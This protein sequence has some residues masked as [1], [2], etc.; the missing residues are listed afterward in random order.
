MVALAVAWIVPQ[1][2]LLGL[3]VIPRFLA[4]SALAFAPVFLA[5]LIF[6]VTLTERQRDPRMRS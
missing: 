3:P 5:N 6:A 1:G 2:S 4:A